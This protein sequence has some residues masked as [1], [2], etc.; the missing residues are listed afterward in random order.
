MTCSAGEQKMV[1]MLGV[2][3]GFAS[4]GAEQ[5]APRANLQTTPAIVTYQ[6]NHNLTST[7]QYDQAGA[8]IYFIDSFQGVPKKVT[9]A[10]FVTSI[11]SQGSNDGLYIGNGRRLFSNNTSNRH[12]YGVN[13]SQA[14]SNG[15]TVANNIYSVDL[16]TI[17]LRSGA[18]T[19][20]EYIQGTATKGRPFDVVMQDDGTIDFAAL[21]LCR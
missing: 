7:R 5:V 18:G 2:D 15:W 20:L 10:W 14:A 11:K 19:L 3:D 12:A 4:S 16:S 17:D 6:Q 21:V 9:K 13:I 8:N 1:Y